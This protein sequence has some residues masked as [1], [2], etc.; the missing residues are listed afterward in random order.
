M[1]SD[2]PLQA[3][4]LIFPMTAGLN[5][6]GWAHLGF[7]GLLL[8]YLVWRSRGKTVGAGGPLPNRLLHL[9]RTVM[10]GC[11]FATLS[12]A[13]AKVQRIDLFPARLPPPAAW[14]AGVAAYAAAVICMRP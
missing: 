13:V 10:E 14:V 7:F 11:L 3:D 12:L 5:P 8:P 9:Q 4:Q 1:T 2:L 6:G